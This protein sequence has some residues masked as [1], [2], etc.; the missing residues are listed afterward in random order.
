M[1]VTMDVTLAYW[2]NLTSFVILRILR[3]PDFESE[4][5]CELT[6]EVGNRTGSVELFEQSQLL[7]LDQYLIIL[8]KFTKCCCIFKRSSSEAQRWFSTMGH[9]W[10]GG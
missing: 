7:I 2:G 1:D 6:Y 9:I 3:N 10:V 5:S 4:S 8:E